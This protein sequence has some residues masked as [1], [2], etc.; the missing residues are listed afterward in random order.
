MLLFIL[1]MVDEE[2]TI[3][4]VTV[5]DTDWTLKGIAKGLLHPGEGLVE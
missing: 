1:F 3:E 2:V 5:G 4:E